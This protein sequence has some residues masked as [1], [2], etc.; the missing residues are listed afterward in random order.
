MKNILVSHPHSSVFSQV[1][2]SGFHR[3]G[4]LSQYC[5]GVAGPEG[6]LRA[7]VIDVVGEAKPAVKNRVLPDAKM[8][9]VSHAALEL[10][11]RGLG[12]LREAI[13]V[14]PT[15]Y[16]AMFIGH[17]AAVAA[18]LWDNTEAVYAYEDGA[19]LTFRRAEQRG[20]P[21]IWDLP[22]PHYAFLED[23]MKREQERWPGAEGSAPK[24]EL[25]WKKKRKDKE[26]EMATHVS[27]ASTFTKSS[28]EALGYA[29]P[30]NVIPYG[31]PT[32]RFLPKPKMNEGAFTILSVGSQNLRK[33]TPYLL[34]A[35]KKADLKNA[36]LL[37]I[38][39]LR[40]SEEFLKPYEGLY[41]HIPHASKEELKVHYKDADV[42]AFPT[43]GDGFGL[44]IQEAMCSAT[45]VITTKCGGGPECITSGEDG[46]VI[47]ERNIDALTDLFV[48]CAENREWTHSIGQAARKRSEAWTWDD[49]AKA[50]GQWARSL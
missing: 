24:I 37:L 7:R 6:S 46:W 45:P 44:V 49:A 39:P 17:D 4:V 21:R 43:L 28:I 48:K 27:V 15:A 34:E 23:M 8:H 42:L 33:G 25:D 11:A 18:S 32:E 2:A 29:G 1:V 9:V 12:R 19:E 22:L 38:G 10:A 47:E 30:M 13:G 31:F 40:L 14:G 41:E 36:R 5:T 3:A 50:F 26:L 16:D 20:I 35:F